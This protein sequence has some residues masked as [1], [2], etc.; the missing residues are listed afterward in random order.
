MLFYYVLL[1]KY[2][3][4]SQPLWSRRDSTERLIVILNILYSI[5]IFAKMKSSI[6]MSKN[7]TCKWYENM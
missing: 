2:T 5:K 7:Y 3:G 4:I 6:D 1:L